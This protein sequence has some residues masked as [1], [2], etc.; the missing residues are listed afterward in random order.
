MRGLT[1]CDSGFLCSGPSSAGNGWAGEEGA[2]E[3]SQLAEKRATFPQR[4][5]LAS[6]YLHCLSDSSVHGL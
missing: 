5:R 6:L 2:P 3:E 4:S 1:S